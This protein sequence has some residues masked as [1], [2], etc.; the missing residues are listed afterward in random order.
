MALVEAEGPHVGGEGPVWVA[1]VSG[2]QLA[3]SS[4]C[5]G[6]RF[7]S[8]GVGGGSRELGVQ[9]KGASA[10]PRWI[11]AA[12]LRHSSSLRRRRSG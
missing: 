11:H 6:G 9:D 4:I 5:M 10:R 3:L 1:G 8:G 7:G 12:A 2:G